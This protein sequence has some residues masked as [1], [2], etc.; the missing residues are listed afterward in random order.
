MNGKRGK[1]NK[2]GKKIY[3]RGYTENGTTYMWEVTQEIERW[4]NEGTEKK[5]NCNDGS[6]TLSNQDNNK[7]IN[8]DL[9]IQEGLDWAEDLAITEAELRSDHNTSYKV[10]YPHPWEYGKKLRAKNTEESLEY[11][12][13]TELV[14]RYLNKIE[15]SEDIKIINSSEFKTYATKHPDKLMINND[16]PKKGDIFAWNGHAGIVKSYNSTTKKVTTIESISEQSYSWHEGIKFDGVVI[17][18]Y[19][20]DKNHLRDNKKKGKIIQYY[21]P[22]KHYSK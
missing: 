1:F 10:K 2:K 6:C 14:C 11:M 7:L 19:D 22:L 21:T 9:K 5:N 17:W 12:D 18:T 3:K 8:S 15:W 4:Y 20:K 13:C 16:S